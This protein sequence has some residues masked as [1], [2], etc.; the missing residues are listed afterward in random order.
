MIADLITKTDL[1][2]FKRELMV[3]IKSF[4][5][6]PDL[7]RK[8]WLKSNEVKEIL[9]CSHGTL[10]NLRINGSLSPTKVGGTWYYS[11]EQVLSLL[12]KAD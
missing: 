1:Q 12:N 10:Q 4:L 7:P 6:T 11:N 9:G 8:A 2:E 3:E 5:T